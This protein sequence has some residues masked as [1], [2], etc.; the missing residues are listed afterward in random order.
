[1]VWGEIR[2]T[3]VTR[4]EFGKS[5]TS[6]GTAPTKAGK[7]KRFRVR[8][9]STNLID[10]FLFIGPPYILKKFE[11]INSPPCGGNPPP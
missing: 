4:A 3:S 2:V 7:M 6:F 9:D 5:V 8:N 10:N 1:M 11:F